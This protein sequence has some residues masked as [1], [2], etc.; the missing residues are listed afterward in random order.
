MARPTQI[1]QNN[2]F[3][4]SLQYLKK[5]VRDKVDFLRNEHQCFL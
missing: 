2:R 4:K 1:T 5:D 3:S